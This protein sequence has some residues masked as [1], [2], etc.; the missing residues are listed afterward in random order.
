MVDWECHLIGVGG[1][2]MSALARL[3][4]QRGGRVSGSDR[5][6]SA[7]LEELRKEG[8][9]LEGGAAPGATVVYSTDIPEGHPELEQARLSGSR[10]WHRSDLLAELMEGYR[11]LTVAGSHGK[12]TTTALLAWT[13][14][15]GGL[16][17]SFALGGILRTL[18][19]N[20]ASG[21]GDLFVA[22]A[23]ESDGTLV[24]Y[25]SFGAIL[26]G[27]E[28]DHMNFF[29]T[30]E[31]LVE[32]F[33]RYIDRVERRDLFFWCGDDPVLRGL[34]P[35]GRTYGFSEGCEWRITDW[36]QSGFSIRFSVNGEALELPLTGRHN[37][38]NGAA[39]YGLCRSLGLAHEQIR[40]GFRT[41]PG[42]ERRCERRGEVRKV[43][44]LDD[45]AH[46]PTE[47]RA[48]LAAV[49]SAAQGRRLIACFQPHRYTRLE[50]CMEAFG[51]AF[52]ECDLL[53]LTDLYSAGESPI[54][55]VT[56]ERLLQEVER[57]SKT[58]CR[59]IPRSELVEQLAEE[60][61][62]HDILLMMGA[63]D[64]TAAA[65]EL[66]SAMEVTPPRKYRVALLS[67]G[68]SSEHEVSRIS[69][70][71]IAERLSTD[72]YEVSDL[73]LG[74]DGELVESK[75]L[76]RVV[77]SEVV[78]PVFH[79]PYGEDGMYAG[80]FEA[81]GKAYVGCSYRSASVAMDKGMT[82][83][84]ALSHGVPTAPFIE[85]SR[86]TLAQ[87][88]ELPFTLPIFVKPSHLGSSIGVEKIERW[89]ELL[90][91][92]ERALALDDSLIIEQGIVGR[93]IEFAVLGNREIEIPPPGEVLTGGRVYDYEAKYGIHQMATTASAELSDEA[94][95]E[96]CELTGR[97]YR[98]LGCEGLA[99]IDFFFDESGGWWLNE[100]NPFPGFTSGS[101]YPRIWGSCGLAYGDLIDRLII[102]ALER[103]RRR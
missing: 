84:L 95:A 55:G 33:L 60:V 52:E 15:Q 80:L 50:Q 61:R 101:L 43:V 89:E 71:N 9:R 13:L 23:D 87:L 82:K 8:V 91:A 88:D 46:H 69:A 6:M 67:G 99:R 65:G 28:A 86:S 58:P 19:T 42:V 57:S 40:E 97:V 76:E 85:C 35:E 39:V 93:E 64:I 73:P 51:R 70:Q 22:E 38:S 81:L 36:S 75:L 29:Q 30:E 98:A 24:K 68:R 56:S 79:G 10:L 96:G 47:V 44:V 102:L 1:I 66:V 31:R 14:L 63:G 7:L 2:G 94:I 48:T 32:T 26:T 103:G 78:V 20:G 12:T 25:P 37:A 62:P 11:C 49:R 92:V 100:V 53:I 5:R 74:R 83:R 54:A 59:L 21:E 72:L 41:F 3:L 27:I 18:G 34:N 90:P 77:E 45:Y 16:D 4:L 17:P